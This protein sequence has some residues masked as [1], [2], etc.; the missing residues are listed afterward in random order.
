[1]LPVMTAAICL[2]TA[3]GE[4]ED[5]PA[6]DNSGTGNVNPA[7]VIVADPTA[8]A[9]LANLL[10]C[11]FELDDDGLLTGIYSIEY[12]IDENGEEVLSETQSLW[13]EYSNGT[14]TIRIEEPP[15]DGTIQTICQYQIGP[16]GFANS[17]VQV[18]TG[19]GTRE[20]WRYFYDSEG[21]LI[22]INESGDECVLRYEGGNLAS[23][24]DYSDE[25]DEVTFS[26]DGTPNTIGYMPYILDPEGFE[27]SFREVWYAYLAGILGRPSAELPVSAH[28]D[29]HG[30]F[31]NEDMTARYVYDRETGLLSNILWEE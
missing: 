22:K 30:R 20:Y 11:R 18:Y 26:Y 19:D 15:Y 9:H 5:I 28:I 25:E 21:H 6:I 16:N 24:T 2:T 17:M 29:Y 3:C 7:N 12:D 27:S 23:Y 4:D 31:S 8:N 14:A 13:Y 10:S 1:M